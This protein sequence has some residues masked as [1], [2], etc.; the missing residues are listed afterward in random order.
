M[1]KWQWHGWLVGWER[2]RQWPN[3]LVW[4]VM[5]AVVVVI[6]I[7]VTVLI[8]I[9]VPMLLNSSPFFK[10]AIKMSMLLKTVFAFFC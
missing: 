8:A 9:V 7:A 3:A 10:D 5:I 6:F 4:I 1:G 2:L